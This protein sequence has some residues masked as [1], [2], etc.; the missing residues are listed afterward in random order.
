[1]TNDLVPFQFETQSV[2]TVTDDQGEP[3]FVAADVCDVLGLENVSK[4]LSRLDTDEKR[5]FRS[6]DV[7]N[8]Y[9]E[10]WAVN[11]S[12]VY[13]LIFTSRKPEAEQFRKWITSEVLPAIRK[14][15]Q[16]ALKPPSPAEQLLASAQM[17]VDHERQLAQHNERLKAIEARQSSIEEG[18]QYFTVLAYAKLH[19]IALDYTAAQ[20]LG[21]RAANYSR[22]HGIAI[23]KVS[24]PRHGTVNSY[25]V[26]VLN[27]IFGER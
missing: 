8:S 9:R 10:F 5:V 3:W 2:R 14:T 23:G 13:H 25:H 17:L 6:S 18:S 7:S 21:Q 22:E 12:G 4:A 1:M 11:E 24:D 20:S 27:V 19:R 26:E 16:Y 15:G